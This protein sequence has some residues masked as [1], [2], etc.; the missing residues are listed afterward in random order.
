MIQLMIEWIPVSGS[1][2]IVAEAY[3]ASTE[4][5]YVRFL[6]GVEWWYSSCPPAIWASFTSPNQSRGEYIDQVLDHKPYGRHT[7]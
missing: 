6:D 7:G 2:R 5:I 3:D 1:A 4:T